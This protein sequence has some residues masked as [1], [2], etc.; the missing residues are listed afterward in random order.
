M[1]GQEPA[2][3][4]KGAGIRACGPVDRQIAMSSD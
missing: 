4:V 1:P 3:P 2:W